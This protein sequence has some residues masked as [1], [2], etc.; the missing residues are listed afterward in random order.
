MQVLKSGENPTMRHLG[1]ARRVHLAWLS[2]VFRKCDQV[3]IAYCNTDEQAAD[4]LTKGFTN[5]QV[6]ER[7]RSLIGVMPISG[8]FLGHFYDKMTKGRETVVGGIH[9]RALA[10]SAQ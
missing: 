2:E 4:L 9:D 6:W 1:R 7:V 10:Q 8:N 3:H 5:P